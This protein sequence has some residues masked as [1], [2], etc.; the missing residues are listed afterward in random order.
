MV[1]Y[2]QVIKERKN[3]LAKLLAK[4]NIEVRHGKYPTA[5][6]DPKAR[7]LCLPEWDFTC[8]AFLDMLIAHEVSHAHHSTKEDIERFVEE[9]GRAK[10]PVWNIIEDIRIERLIQAM[11]PGLIA[12]F[13]TAYEH[14]AEIDLMQLA[15]KPMDKRLF[16]DRINIHAK[17][18][19]FVSVPLSAKE[20]DFYD[21]CM[22]AETPS[23]VLELCREAIPIIEEEQRENQDEEEGDGDGEESSSDDESQEDETSSSSGG[24]GDDDSTESESEDNDPTEAPGD[25]KKGSADEEDENASTS[26]QGDP[27]EPTDGAPDD[28]T[29]YSATS[30]EAMSKQLED[31]VDMSSGYVFHTPSDKTVLQYVVPYEKVKASR[32]SNH[33]PRLPEDKAGFKAFKREQTT[34]IAYLVSEFERKK[35]AYQYSHGTIARS[36]K[37]DVNALHRYKL[38]DDI[39]LSLNTMADAKSHGMLM[40]IDYSG[41]MSYIL[42]DTIKQTLIM[43]MFCQ[44][45]GIPFEVY[46]FTSECRNRPAEMARVL[47]R[48]G[49]DEMDFGFGED[50][51]GGTNVFELLS[52]RLKK[53]D[54]ADAMSD[55]YLSRSA[56][57]D[58]TNRSNYEE[59]G[60]TPLQYSII[61]SQAIIRRFKEANR[62]QKISV[63]FLTDGDAS[64]RISSAESQKLPA[65][66]AKRFLF[67]GKKFQAKVAF[68]YHDDW[69]VRNDLTHQLFDSLRENNDI[70]LIGY[71]LVHNFKK[72]KNQMTAK[73]V[74]ESRANKLAHLE[75]VFG[76][77]HFFIIKIDALTVMNDIFSDHD[78]DD[79]VINVNDKKEVGNLRK[80]FKT[81][82]SNR[83]RSRVF[84]SKFSDVIA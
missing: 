5:M 17:I 75:A 24:E 16:I 81:G 32:D 46:G 29:D 26:A 30:D 44:K 72:Y 53:N 34:H 64:D 12:I 79:H 4:E 19:R 35:A 41:S 71:H 84:L 9:F 15:S 39:F 18:G 31:S 3:L 2:L 37:L 82:C 45:V 76:Y 67:N 62:V 47:P 20:R 78:A 55:L 14:A 28:P 13:R 70:T 38:D 63:I 27:G 40:F 66:D 7:V 33:G 60:G 8:E 51:W 6:F 68:S 56:G 42:G 58:R 69:R 43:S 52:S 1:Q 48:I 59:L 21:R 23:D 74:S 73:Q 25:S 50:S 80:T 49:P 11:Y 65:R 54:L 77:D 83:K 36:G 10:F 61:I 57:Y 22:L